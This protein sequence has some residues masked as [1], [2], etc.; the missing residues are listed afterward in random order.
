MNQRGEDVEKT[1]VGI[2]V[3]PSSATLR[4]RIQSMAQT[5]NSSIYILFARIIILK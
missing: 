3:V 2:S 5:N 1:K 4:L